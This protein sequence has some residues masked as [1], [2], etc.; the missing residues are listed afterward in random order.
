MASRD[1]SSDI[2]RRLRYIIG[3]NLY[4][5]FINKLGDELTITATDIGLAAGGSNNLIFKLTDTD[6][7][8]GIAF[9]NGVGAQRQR[10]KALTN[11]I[12]G[13]AT[14]TIAAVNSVNTAQ[15]AIL[16][17]TAKVNAILTALNSFG[18]LDNA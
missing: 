6:L 8:G 7:N 1:I 2:E 15:T 11:G 9:F 18:L 3:E 10:V 16:N 13:T 17:L 4:I 5:D 12:T 14:D